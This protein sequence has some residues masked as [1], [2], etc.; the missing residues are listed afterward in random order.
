MEFGPELQPSTKENKILSLF[1]TMAHSLLMMKM[2]ASIGNKTFE[3]LEAVKKW[4]ELEFDCGGN[5]VF[6]YYKTREGDVIQ[7]LS[8][9]YNLGDDGT[10][11]D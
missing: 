10:V 8:K 1:S 6:A 2:L 7:R 3:D 11:T 9:K 5:V 4:F